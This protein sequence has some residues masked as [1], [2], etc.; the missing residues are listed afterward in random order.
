VDFGYYILNTYVP[1]LDGSAA[2][3][4]GRYIEQVDAA[5]ALGFDTV[6]ATEHH[7]RHF[8]GLT[9]SPQLLLTTLS[10]RVR[11]V[12]L[13]TSVSILPLH[14]PLRI[15]ED[16]AMLDVLSAGRLEF[17]VGRGMV[18]SGY[19]GYRS[20]WADAQD[21]M[22][23]ALALIQLAWT[24]PAVTFAGQHYQC[25]EVMVLPRPAQQ[26]RPAIWVTAST[27]PASFRWI[28]E[29]GY[30]LMLVPWL[31]P[32]AAQNVSVFREGRAAGGH[33]GPGRV[34]A[35]YPT[36]VAETDPEARAA[37]KP[38]WARWQALLMP[39]MAPNAA[40]RPGMSQQVQGLN[41]D[42]MV[43]ERHALFGTVDRCVQHVRWM[44]ET[45]GLTHL[46]LTF[47]FGGMP[48]TKAL[49]AMELWSRHV[50]P[51]FRNAR[52]SSPALG[53]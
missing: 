16:F 13:G 31:F 30:G 24:E 17:G 45:F 5:E 37:A 3:V 8:G 53:A 23:E 10:Q 44:T 41:Y 4:Y 20:D 35:M 42:V 32:I 19:A 40:N 36:H 34:M 51:H 18:L 1:E 38:A 9:P 28:G 49:R 7:F 52:A 50:A 26:P 39:E 15:A 33:P 21:R 14:Q 12:R 29:Q 47:Y 48:H 46:G 2:D 11:R 22:K 25:S 6:W 43:G 27:D